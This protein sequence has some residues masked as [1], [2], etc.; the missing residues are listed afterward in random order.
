MNKRKEILFL[1]TGETVQICLDAITERKKY[2]IISTVVSVPTIQPLDDTF[3]LEL[4]KSHRSVVVC[5]AH[6][7]HG[8]LG[9]AIAK[10]LIEQNIICKFVLLGIPDAPLCNGSKW[11]VLATYGISRE[12]ITKTVLAM[13]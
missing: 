7:I 1:A 10:L 6:S 4:C 13:T 11:D 12:G 3:V 9:E 5:E 8:K 2:E